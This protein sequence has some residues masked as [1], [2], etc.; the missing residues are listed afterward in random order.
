MTTQ[1]TQTT[2]TTPAPVVAPAVAAP[3][4]HVPP[5]AKLDAV[6]GLSGGVIP[7]GGGKPVD[8]FVGQGVKDLM[9]A[10][11]NQFAK[12]Q[13]LKAREAAIAAA[14]VVT[15]PVTPAAP[16]VAA[17]PAATV[18][19]QAQWDAEAKKDVDAVKANPKFKYVQQFGVAEMVPKKILEHYET[20]AKAGKAE[21]LT[22]DAVAQQIEDGLRKDVETFVASLGFKLTP[23]EQAAVVAAATQAPPVATAQ[24]QAAA[25]VAATELKPLPGE[26]FK[27]FNARKQGKAPANTVTLSNHVAPAAPKVEVAV[28]KK[29]SFKEFNARKLKEQTAAS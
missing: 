15:P 3:A 24:Q 12:E 25:P 9:L 10:R 7:A 6:P 28:A 5:V 2:Q 16:V 13:E 29:E 18:D 11:A 22:A 1:T 19:W 27:E 23:A 17:A 26:S 21:Y 8:G 20:T 4:V 14:P